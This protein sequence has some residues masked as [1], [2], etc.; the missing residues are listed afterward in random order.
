MVGTTT[1]ANLNKELT[2]AKELAK[3]IKTQA[4]QSGVY[5]YV[6]LHSNANNINVTGYIEF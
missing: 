5:D 3:I 4:E 1:I 2:N 6:E